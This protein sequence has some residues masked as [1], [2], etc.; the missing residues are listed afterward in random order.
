[1]WAGACSRDALLIGGCGRTDFQGGDASTLYRSIHE[2]IF[3]L[4]K[5]A[6]VY[7]AH[8]YAGKTHSTIGEEIESN[9]RLGSGMSEG[10]FVSLMDARK[11]P[12][13]KRID[14]AVP[15]NMQCGEF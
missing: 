15:A 3:T 1:M 12:Y 4:D 6:T 5:R 14:E 7:P 10:D 2:E 13:P 8:D 9:P 11:M